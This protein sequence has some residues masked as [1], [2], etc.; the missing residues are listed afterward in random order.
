LL[1]SPHVM[2]CDQNHPLP[3]GGTDFIT[4]RRRA[5]L[6]QGVQQQLKQ[7]MQIVECRREV[8]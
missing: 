1:S 6:A 3:R 7:K 4:A 8:E 2:K 5:R